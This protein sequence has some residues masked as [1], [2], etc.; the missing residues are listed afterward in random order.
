MVDFRGERR[1][2]GSKVS[3]GDGQSQGGEL[4]VGRWL[5]ARWEGKWGRT[6]ACQRP[7]VERV[8]LAWY[9]GASQ[10]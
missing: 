1:E 9:F 8:S 5:R 7:D 10:G 3:E 4:V 6:Q 2:T